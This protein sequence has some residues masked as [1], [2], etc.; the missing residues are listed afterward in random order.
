MRAQLPEIPDPAA[1]RTVIR[2]KRILLRIP[3]LLKR[4]T[5]N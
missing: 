5:L 2:R 3:R 1:H 4:E